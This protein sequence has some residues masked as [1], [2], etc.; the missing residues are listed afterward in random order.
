VD[1]NRIKGFG[2]TE[3]L[4]G[5]AVLSSGLLAIYG[6]H[7]S[8]IK[9]FADDREKAAMMSRLSSEM[10]KAKSFSTCNELAIYGDSL[11]EVSMV[12]VSHNGDNTACDVTVSGSWSTP[13]SQ[14]EVSISGMVFL[15]NLKL[16]SDDE[17]N[18]GDGG[19]GVGVAASPLGEA[20][21]GDG[22]K[23]TGGTEYESETDNQFGL[24]VVKK[25]GTFYLLDNIDADGGGDNLLEASNLF[26]RIRGRIYLDGSSWNE[27]DFKNVY[28]GAPDTSVCRTLHPNSYSKYTNDDSSNEYFYTDYICYVGSGWYGSIGVT[29]VD[30]S[31]NGANQFLL[32][33]ADTCVGDP[34]ANDVGSVYSLHSTNSL[35]RR[36]TKYKKIENYSLSSGGQTLI[37]YSDEGFPV[38]TPSEASYETSCIYTNQDFVISDSAACTSELNSI[39]DN[40]AS[41]S[42]LF[43]DTPGKYVCLDESDFCPY[44]ITEP[45]AVSGAVTV[46][47]LVST[48]VDGLATS[49]SGATMT[50]SSTDRVSVVDTGNCYATVDNTAYWKCD[51]TPAVGEGFSSTWASYAVGDVTIS[52]L[53]D[54]CTGDSS[55]S[56][57][58]ISGSSVTVP[59]IKFGSDRGQFIYLEGASCAGTPGDTGTGTGTGNSCS[60]TLI[61]P[62]STY[63]EKGTSNS[64]TYTALNANNIV[65]SISN[66]GISDTTGSPF[67]V[68]NPSGNNQDV[69]VT[70]SGKEV[71]TGDA[72]TTDT[73]TFTTT[74]NN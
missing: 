72:C 43:S 61:P 24:K 66:G 54:G 58:V 23:I 42:A 70:L 49:I 50:F 41:S 1:L 46:D 65:I 44:L 73:V 10:T 38:C 51:V 13:I 48:Q 25:D 67:T 4:I 2:L 16:S 40:Y 21:Y 35:T 34:D 36:Y 53:P 52:N 17:F 9:S 8:Y 15:R 59:G 14:G 62:S 68:T 33:D 39:E 7:T 5:L 69:I 28:A 22:E 71:G 37:K 45:Y 74:N 63:T 60:L 19:T 11:S 12:A 55:R 27:D 32:L 18:E 56:D 57:Q 29:E 20:I 64:W 30:Q 3:G 6:V 26:Y 47:G 31:G